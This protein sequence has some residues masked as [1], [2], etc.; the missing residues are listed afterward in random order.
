MSL[1]TL[2][3]RSSLQSTL[4]AK[5]ALALLATLLLV[6]LGA[7]SSWA[8]TPTSTATATP[9]PT[10]APTGTGFLQI[11]KQVSGGLTGTFTFTVAPPT[12]A[13]QTVTVP[14]GACSE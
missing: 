3:L 12:G 14:A 8:Q 6:L 9:T 11:C 2:W 1:F 13:A 5:L 10:L 7:S 4:G